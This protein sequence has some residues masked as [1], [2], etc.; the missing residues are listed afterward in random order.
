MH[1]CKIVDH[2]D[3]YDSKEIEDVEGALETIKI[4][5]LKQSPKSKKQKMLKVNFLL[6]YIRYDKTYIFYL[7]T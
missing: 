2:K 6:L 7:C 4:S 3:G 1:V 5:V